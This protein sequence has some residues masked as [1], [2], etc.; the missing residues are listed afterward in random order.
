M[1][2]MRA[3]REMGYE[4]VCIAPPDERVR[5]I[6]DNGFRFV[7]LRHLSR[8]G[9]NLF[10]DIS[11]TTEL[12]RLYKR[13][14]VALAL[15]FTIKPNIYGAIAASW[16]GIG[17][18]C[19]ITGLG[20][21]F[22]SQGFVH[23]LTKLLFRMAFRRADKVVFQNDDD[24][25]LFIE[26]KLVDL[27]KTTI[28]KGSGVNTE[29][30]KPMPARRHSDGKIRLLY[31]GRL[32]YDKGL[33]ELHEASRL[34][35]PEFPQLEFHIVGGIDEGNPSAI[36]REFLENWLREQVN[37]TYHGETD[38]IRPFIADADIIVLPSY[39]EGLP[40][41]NLEAMCMEKPIITT[42]V[43]GCKDTVVEGK[44]GLKTEVRNASSLSDAIRKMIGLNEAQRHAM[45][46]T[47]RHIAIRDFD[48]KIV[49][50]HYLSV[51][52][53]AL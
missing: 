11:L 28:I 25:Q 42:D 38:D 41:T 15:H 6:K 37:V 3:L 49:I 1:G 35:S 22:L 39:R 4:V 18:V 9:M 12:Y 24:R 8:K 17:S 53:A 16:A 13:E 23:R 45:G 52:H 43:P 32:L 21:T 40:R 51:I 20:Y 50:S 34:L 29:Y 26:S 31:I 10:R 48:E 7:P 2:L 44:N 14:D 46:V 19:T 33:R 5:I 36:H 47:G 27:T 30:F